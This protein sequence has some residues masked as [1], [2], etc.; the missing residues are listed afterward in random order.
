MA[1]LVTEQDK[2]VIIEKY[3]TT[4]TEE[5]AKELGFSSSTIKMWAKKLKIKK[6]KGYIF[7]NTKNGKFTKEEKIFIYEHY[8]T[9]S[10]KEISEI[11]NKPEDLILNYA[12]AKGLKKRADL[13]RNIR[14]ALEY[15]IEKRQNPNYNYSLY[16]GKENE[17]KIPEEELYISKYGK[18]R[19]NQNYF[20]KI[21]NEWKAYWLGFLYADGWNTVSKNSIGL[22]LRSDD[23]EHIYKFKQSVQ[24]DN[25]VYF[26][27]PKK[28]IICG[29]ESY[30]TGTV[31]IRITNKNLSEKL[32][33]LGCVENKTYILQFPN[34]DIVPKE[35]MRHFI[36]G[37]FDGDGWV[38][39]LEKTKAPS[40]G[41]VGMETFILPMSQY[42]IK[43]LKISQI[44]HS[45]KNLKKTIE[46]DWCSLVDVEKIFNYLYNN[47]NIYLE[48]KFD[49]LN[50]FYCL[51]QYEV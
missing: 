34:F 21:D 31:S 32:A 11:L 19:V 35:L 43:E 18:Y 49:K 50:K 22:T 20:D 7:H 4:D 26:S 23:K 48:R 30:S 39:V 14:G 44:K 51:G 46:I 3:P 1:K 12:C 27:N 45:Q 36:R 10:N 16:I 33:A 37:I 29:K 28:V 47:A 38:S 40:V 25:K 41:F 24:S 13:F 8:S 15:F 2:K 9:K 17:P 5:L 6:K 42:L